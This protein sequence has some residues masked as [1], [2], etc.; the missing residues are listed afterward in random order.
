MHH[1]ARPN[2]EYVLGLSV[3]PHDEFV[4]LVGQYL[5]LLGGPGPDQL[6]PDRRPDDVTLPHVSDP[7]HQT[8]FSVPLTDDR[9]LG[10]QQGLGALL[11]SRHLGEDDPHHERLNHHPGDALD[12]HD[13]YGL[14]AL[15]RGRPATVTD[16]VLGLNGEQK[17]A[18]ETVQVAHARSP[19][20]V[21]VV[22]RVEVAVGEGYE[23]PYSG[24][25]QP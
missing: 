15:L 16:G 18:G 10:E 23:V 9:L 3:G 13:E 22:T 17:A 14:G 21:L 19:I 25:N 24:E 4:L 7:E 20:L 8:K 2:E 11:G 5:T 12:A 6:R 1:R